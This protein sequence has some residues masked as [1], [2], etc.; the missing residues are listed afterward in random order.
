[1]PGPPSGGRK[2]RLRRLLPRLLDAADRELPTAVQDELAVGTSESSARWWERE[3]T[4]ASPHFATGCR[5]LVTCRRRSRGTSTD[6]WASLP[7]LRLA[8]G[9]NTPSRERTGFARCTRGLGGHR[10]GQ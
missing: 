7:A 1:M 3:C 9:G 6:G 4:R 2:L 8:P 5:R 10:V